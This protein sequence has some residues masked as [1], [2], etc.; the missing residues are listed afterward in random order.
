[1]GLTPKGT[2]LLRRL[3]ITAAGLAA[4]GALAACSGA[5][6][7]STDSP[8]SAS[9]DPSSSLQLQEVRA[10]QA[11][12][13]QYEQ[14]PTT[15]GVTT[16][17]KEKPKPGGTFVWLNCD[18]DQCKY[19]AKGIQEATQAIGWHFKEIPFQTANPATLVA[20]LQQALTY[21]PTAVA[22]SGLPPAVWESAAKAYSQAG[23]PIV[24]AF[25]G[26][27]QSL[28]KPPIIAQVGGDQDVQAY[29]DMLAQ[30]FIAD[31]QARGQEVLL[32]VNDFPILKTFSDSFMKSVT[33]GCSACKITDVNATIPQVT[34]GQTVAPLVSAVQK[35]PSIKYVISSELPYIS[36]IQGQLAA[37][38]LQGVKIAGDSADVQGLQLLKQGIYSATTGASLRYAGWLM[39]DQAL[40][41]LQ[42]MPLPPDGGGLPK[43]LLTPTTQFSVSVD[44]DKPT[45]FP[46]QFMRLWHV[47]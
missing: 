38:G 34:S 18:I 11:K 17:L 31:S 44:Y 45:N 32:S 25:V 40:R 15:I 47:G 3:V 6:Y 42:R 30:W 23:V 41:Y 2:P 35:D 14:A 5:T 20:A 8:L 4:L 13:A 36:G 21:K 12:V 16:P 19:E 43:Q 28:V 10:A 22:L 39:V 33:D 46:E 29:G 24:I 9:S 26:G 37:A 7:G 1:M 27:G